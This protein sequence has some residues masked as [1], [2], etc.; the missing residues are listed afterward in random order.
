MIRK[1]LPAIHLAAVLVVGSVTWYLAQ[2][3]KLAPLTRLNLRL[4]DTLVAQGSKTGQPGQMIFLALDESSLDLSQMAEEDLANSR[5]L[6]LMSE[7]FP[8]SREVYAEAMNKVLAAGA[9]VVALDILINHPGAGD[10]ALRQTLERNPDRTVMV[11]NF[12]ELQTDSGHAMHILTPISESVWPPNRPLSSGLGFANFF[13]DGDKVVRRAAYAVTLNEVNLRPRIE[14][15]EDVLSLAAAVNKGSGQPASLPDQRQNRFRPAREDA[16]IRIPLWQIFDEAFWQ[17]NLQNGAIFEGKP[18]L[19][20]PQAKRF[21]DFH[22]TPWNDTAPGPEIHLE[23]LSALQEGAFFKEAP[24]WLNALALLLV[25]GLACAALVLVQ[26]PFLSTALLLVLGVSLVGG[27]FAFYE[28]ASLLIPPLYP[29]A[30]L[31]IYGLFGLTLNFA[32]E[33]SERSRVRRTFERY[34]SRDV[35]R[36]ILDQQQSILHSLGGARKPACILFSDIRGFTSMTESRDPADVVSQLNQYLGSMVEQV[37]DQQG[38]LDKFIG[39]AVMATWGTV[40]TKGPEADSRAAVTS[41]LGMLGA[42]AELNRKWEKENKPVLRIGV[43]V[44]RG[45]VIFGNIG[46]EKKMEPTVIGDAVNTAAR[47]E[48]LTKKYG[49]SLILSDSIGRMVR[50]HFPLQTVDTVKVVG[51]QQAL[52]LYTVC[53]NEDQQ[54]WAPTWLEHHEAGWGKFRKR[55]FLEAAAEF[56]TCLEQNPAEQLAARMAERCRQLIKNPPPEDWQPVTVFDEK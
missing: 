36:E 55:Q 6:R 7:S 48:S 25:L 49:L 2:S 31:A 46:S 45:E 8:W 38:T 19:I 17:N 41:A 4:E 51:R 30:G 12:A 10:A 43:A 23:A 50:K 14:G 24:G 11:V 33:R 16:I 27:I 15:D 40:T 34:V 42:L 5:P 47:L 37:F 53:L 18:V 39:D 35:V 44:H 3:G 9:S 22:P 1:F 54:P 52:S 56:E 29:L 28:L 21:Q 13:P 20:G 32:L 26:R